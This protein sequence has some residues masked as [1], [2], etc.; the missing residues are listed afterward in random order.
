MYVF[1]SQQRCLLSLSAN[2][3]R[4]RG[5]A[6]SFGLSFNEETATEVLLLDL[7]G[8]FPGNVT[9]I[10]FSHSQK[11]QIGGDWA[12][13]F[14]GPGGLPCQGMLVQAKRLDDRDRVYPELLYKGGQGGTGTASSQMERLIANGRRFGLPPVYAFYNHLSDPTRVPTGS[15]RS[16]DMLQQPLPESWGVAIVS[17]ISV[18][19]ARPD[20]TYD[21]HRHHSRPLHCLLCSSGSGRQHPLGSAGAAAAA[22]SVLFEGAGEDDGLRP[23]VV[24]PFEPTSELPELF[25][26]AEELHRVRTT[27]AEASLVDFRREFRGIAGVV[28]V[29]DSEH[30]ETWPDETPRTW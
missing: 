8:Q 10:P 7:A 4:R 23:G 2:I 29:R 17:A 5:A 16:L 18:R 15:C 12:W 6:K 26:N 27:D 22:L 30:E 9:T 1:T 11:A 19:D 13:P 25:Q 28:I 3:W 24:P 14:V 21:R 20:K